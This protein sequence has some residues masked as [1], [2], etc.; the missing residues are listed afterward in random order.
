[1]YH[2]DSLNQGGFGYNR[3]SEW[4]PDQVCESSIHLFLNVW[5]RIG[6]SISYQG[7]RGCN[8]E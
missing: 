4:V 7:K 1:M 2:A 6:D 8:T 3:K 5:F